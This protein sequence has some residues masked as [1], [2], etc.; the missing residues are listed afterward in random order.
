MKKLLASVG[1]V[2]LGASTLNAAYT[3]G[4]SE[5]ETKKPWSVGLTLRGFYDDNI[6]A[7]HANE[8]DSLGYEVNPWV[9]INW[10][11][12][13]TIIGASY[14]YSGKY[15]DET[16][17][18][19]DE[20][21][22]QSH[23]FDA[24]L[25]HAFNPRYNFSV[26]DSFVI[27]Q[28]P[29]Q[30]RSGDSFATQQR[31][32]GDNM[33]NFGQL[34]FNAQFTPVFGMRFGYDNTY[35][36]YDQS[37][38]DSPRDPNTGLTLP[39]FQPIIASYSGLLDRLENSAVI[40]G[41]WQV[42]P[43]TVG[44]LGYRYRLVEYNGDELI[45]GTAVVPAPGANPIPVAG[46]QSD[47]RDYQ[48][49]YGYVGVEHHFR[50]DL[51]AALNAGIRYT[52]HFN[53]GD[54]STDTGPYVQASL[55]YEHSADTTFGIGFSQDFT[56]SDIAGGAGQFVQGVNNSVAYLSC[57]HRLAPSLY[58]SGTGTFQYSVFEG[59]GATYDGE[60]DMF[61]LAGVNLEY[62]FSKHI[63]GQ[64]GYNYDYLDSDIPNRG[65]DRNRVYIGLS[66][67]Y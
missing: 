32:S 55:S 67:T 59:G 9:G 11:G 20:H 52:D 26:R 45:N 8:I 29:D 37:G 64:I 47:F 7:A 15:Y 16:S 4:L 56:S 48:S 33:R 36:N 21:W 39:G 17:P 2:A 60:A 63:S 42:A 13:Q 25:Q 27:G 58:L 41:R 44:I 66:A 1:M 24:I 50:P 40:D 65:Y 5:L 3:Q 49:H 61:F 22:S 43:Q 31:I 51:F 35:W 46:D 62:W 12:D 54:G 23:K 57:R 10:V 14:A 30:L 34:D 6:Q 53:D 28:E 18:D 38:I 19:T